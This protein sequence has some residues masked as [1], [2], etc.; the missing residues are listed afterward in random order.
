M[1]VA[2][3]PWGRED[4]LN[5]KFQDSTPGV[6]LYPLEVHKI[7]LPRSLEKVLS[8]IFILLSIQLLVVFFDRVSEVQPIFRVYD[9]P[10]SSSLV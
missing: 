2:G 3:L 1:R 6:L 4:I 5:S 9:Q 10:G 8:E 7:D